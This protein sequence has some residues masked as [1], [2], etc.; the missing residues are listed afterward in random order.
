MNR[1][2]TIA[3]RGVL[4]RENGRADVYQHARYHPSADLERFVEHYWS[5]Q[6]DLRGRSAERIEVLPHPSVHLI[7]ERDVGGQIVG[8]SK[9]KFVRLLER[10]GGVTAAKFKP[11]G[12]YPFVRKPVSMFS[13][14][15]VAIETVFGSRGDALTAAVLAER[16]DLA[17]IALVE[18]F[19]RQQRPR[20]DN[21]GDWIGEIVYSVAS[22]RTI[23]RVEDLVERHGI[24]HRTLQRL[25]AK[26]VG[27]N[28]KWVIQRYRLHEAA[29]RLAS[30]APV[31]QSSL[32]LDLGYT[33][34]AHFVRDFKTV[35]GTSPAAYARTARIARMGGLSS[36]RS[37]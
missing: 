16:T 17:R 27:V 33:D 3:P 1:R 4:S 30:T 32:A 37:T 14:R 26:Y 8:L 22:D 28:P 20:L 2:K 5:V 21:T 19:L 24:N 18:E 36:R 7:F 23:Q 10:A 35:V 31:S 34:Q 15:I 29:E 9:G 25:F 12:F 11:G 13:D 6:W